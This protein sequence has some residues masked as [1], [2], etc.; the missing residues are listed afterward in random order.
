M[1][2]TLEQIADLIDT[3]YSVQDALR[4]LS[5]TTPNISNVPTSA[6]GLVSGDIW[7]NAGVLTIV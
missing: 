6:T 3:G 5:E 2:S 7:S 4:K 1:K